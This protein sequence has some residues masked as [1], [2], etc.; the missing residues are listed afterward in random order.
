LII[1][2]LVSPS[3]KSSSKYRSYSSS[4][5]SYSKSQSSSSSYSKYSSY[6]N[7]KLF[8]KVIWECP[9]SSSL[10]SSSYSNYY[11]KKKSSYNK[12][13][14][15]KTKTESIFK[16]NLQTS[17]SIFKFLSHSSKI[18]LLLH[19]HVYSNK[20]FVPAIVAKD[21]EKESDISKK[22]S[23]YSSLFNSSSSSKTSKYSS[24]YSSSSSSTKS[25]SSTYKKPDYSYQ[26]TKSTSYTSRR[27]SILDENPAIDNPFLSPH[28]PQL[29]PLSPA[30]VSLVEEEE[31]SLDLWMDVLEHHE[32]S[33]PSQTS[34]L[35]AGEFPLLLSHKISS[36]FPDSPFILSHSIFDIK[37]PSTI[38]S[39]ISSLPP[40]SP[41]LLSSSPST[42]LA[43]YSLLTSPSHRS[44]T[45]GIS[46]F[47]AGVIGSQLIHSN[48]YLHFQLLI[49]DI[50]VR[51]NCDLEIASSLLF[52]I[53][54][55]S[56][57]VFIQIPSSLP[58]V[59]ED[60][61][62]STHNSLEVL[63]SLRFSFK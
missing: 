57:T 35:V 19:E 55:L 20:P 58:S 33:L 32:L 9:K 2:F 14:T 62:I 1:A 17:S 53:I 13:T 42:S 38:Q 6:S 23:S 31:E 27:L 36:M 16:S 48:S 22:Y 29:D 37:S 54:S 46:A 21:V 5:S 51:S 10:T 59:C 52:S 8:T 50:L 45:F 61:N 40:P 44:H 15:T 41:I 26:S 49:V 39:L 25:S 34:V 56:P 47:Q 11:S 43:T 28:L 30:H 12:I 60:L 7:S 18:S 3:T 63:D 4:H 24:K